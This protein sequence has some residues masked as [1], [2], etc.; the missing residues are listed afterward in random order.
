MMGSHQPFTEEIRPGRLILTRLMPGEEVFARLKEISL[1]QGIQRAAVLSAIGS[2]E[3]VVFRNLQDD[4]ALPILLEKTVEFRLH[5]PFEVL[6]LEGNLFPLQNQ[7]FLHLHCL[8]SDFR[9]QVTGGHLFSARAF[10]TLE[11]LLQELAE[12]S[13]VKEKS[14]L[15]GLNE[16]LRP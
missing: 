4:I 1:Q 9:G 2:F 16:L 13:T 14:E 11:I 10:S 8:L 12:C 5:G 7:P 6:S 3:E 15:T